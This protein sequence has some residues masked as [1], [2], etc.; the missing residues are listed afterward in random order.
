MPRFFILRPT[1]QTF[2][3]VLLSINRTYGELEVLFGAKVPARKFA[4]TSIDQFQAMEH[5]VASADVE[6]SS[7]SDKGDATVEG[8]AG[9]TVAELTK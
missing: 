1:L 8:E 9:V 2:V 6:K 4:S 7:V 5:E 3:F